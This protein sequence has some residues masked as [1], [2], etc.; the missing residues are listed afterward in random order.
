MH[1]PVLAA[2]ILATIF[3][4]ALSAPIH[5]SEVLDPA[6][7]PA[8]AYVVADANGHLSLGGQRIR[9]WGAIGNLPSTYVKAEPGETAEQH[10]ARVQDAYRQNEALVQRLIDLGFNLNR[11][12]H[13]VREDYVVGDGSRAD[14]IDQFYATMKRRGLHLWHAGINR[15]GTITADDV[16]IV[17]DPA[18]AAAWSEAVAGWKKDGVDVWNIVRKWDPRFEA[19]SIKRRAEVATHLN[20]HT[21]LRYVDDPVFAAWELTNEEWWISKMVNGA[22]HG[23]PPF[24]QQELQQR[25]IA[26]LTDRYAND[27]ALAKRW[28]KLL[29]G[30]TLAGGS[31]QILP[32]ATPQD[33]STLAI[34]ETAR[35]ALAETAAANKDQK[36]KREDFAR[37]RGEDVLA[38]FTELHVASKRREAEAF[39]ALGRSAKS[40]VLAWDTGIGY[41]IQAQWM[42]QNSDVSVHDAYVN[43]WGDVREKPAS[44]KDEQARWMWESENEAVKANVGPW[45]SWL[46]KPPGIAQGVPWLEHN[47]VPGKPF[48]AYETQIQQPAKYRADFPVRIATLA[49]IQDWDGVCW[50]Y[51]APPSGVADPK[52]WIEPMDNTVGKHPQGYHFTFDEVQTAAMRAAAI[53]WRTGLLEAPATPTTFIYGRKALQDPDSMDY[54]R[55][56][57]LRGLDMLQTVYQYGARI[58]IDPTRD[59]N[60]VRGPVVKIEDRFSHNPYTPTK[61]ITIDWKLGNIVFDAPGVAAFTGFLPKVG[62]SKTFANGV[63]LSDV[64]VNNPEGIYDPVTDG[65]IAFA[66]HSEDGK[67]LATC[68]TAALTLVS[69]S[70]NSGFSLAKK[71]FEKANDTANPLY[72]TAGDGRKNGGLPVLVARVAGTV[73]AKAIDGMNYTMYDWTMQPIGEGTVTGSK[74]SVPADKPVFVIRLTR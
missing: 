26:F 69:T 22:F 66:L 38:F 40:C 51:F 67:S 17:D 44:F 57:G 24:F 7:V 64:A 2:T 39:K 49:A 6:G 53:I 54:G 3:A 1:H 58:L 73:T 61:Q 27:A 35:K 42:Q 16:G 72:A 32:L 10:A 55:S 19:M 23:L 71:D 4:T 30:E 31:V 28:G 45:N 74:L 9:F 62:G 60:E 63:T 8:D 41:E 14:I 65:Y 37:E 15:F 59:D 20:R 11:T 12:W 50:H 21:G 29:P 5:A 43:G 34:D 56:Y 47:K 13:D 46:L 25:W 33:L 48:L 18:T 70:F 68:Q 52:R 36:W